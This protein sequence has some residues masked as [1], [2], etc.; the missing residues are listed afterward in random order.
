MNRT[1]PA[2]RLFRF[3]VLA[4]Q[5]A[6]WGAVAVADAL[7][8]AERGGTGMR[9][10]AQMQATA[11]ADSHACPLCTFLQLRAPV[12][13][14]HTPALVAWET[15]RE[16]LTPL[17]ERRGTAARPTTLPRAPPFTA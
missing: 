3:L 16:S 13:H 6:L 10:E 12:A 7:A 11:P 1:R 4:L 17:P 2:L 5:L 8:H 14:G 15:H 9:V